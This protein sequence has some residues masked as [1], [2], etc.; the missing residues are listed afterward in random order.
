MKFENAASFA[1]HSHIFLGAG[2]AQN[3][4]R[5]WAAISLTTFMMVVEI[6]GGTLFGSVAVVADGFH[7]AT[8]ALAFL[9]A[10]LAYTYARR[11]ATD[12]RFAFGTGK[13]GDLAGYT[14]AIILAMIALG[15]GFEAAARLLSPVT[16]Y[17][18]EAI[19]IA[20]GGLAVNIAT[21]WLLSGGGGYHGHEHGH[22]GS[23]GSEQGAYGHDEPYRIV[24]PQGVFVLEIFEDGVP[25][26][27][28]LSREDGLKAGPALRGKSV[29]VETE[30]R[31]G[32][33]QTFHLTDRGTF[34]E[35]IEDIP[36]PHEFK[37][38]L[39]LVSLHHADEY[40]FNFAGQQHGAAIP[41]KG[42]SRDYNMRAAFAHVAADAAVSIL[43]IC[44]LLLG[45]FL[46]WAFMDP[47]MGIV[48]AL[49]IANWAIG[50]I[51]DTG[52]VL[53]D[54][55]PDKAMAEEL[56]RMIEADGDRLADFHLWRLG[57]GHLGAILSILT[58][59]PRDAEFYHSRLSRFKMLSHLT[60][61]VRNASAFD[62]GN[63]R[64]PWWPWLTR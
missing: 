26:H 62:N 34:L 59:R 32:E 64:R 36:G 27:F 8:H 24:I 39:R 9:L 44:G 13:L 19:L 56:R 12:A 21:A 55:N 17:F 60:I 5:T 22:A 28:R 3:E 10:A 54:M 46:G 25:P 49:V 11:H 35:S 52:G 16:I 47:V 45:R 18:D 40:E 51:R 23:H 38:R 57:P 20:A 14:S 37:A 58:N 2:H 48:G 41:A 53:L 31:G 43:A 4:R 50:L 63:I 30:R 6:A 61:E 15:I 42:A 7:M 33:R 29:I 1:G